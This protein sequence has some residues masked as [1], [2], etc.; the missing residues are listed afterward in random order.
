M[1]F[2]LV[3]SCREALSGVVSTRLIREQE[4][5]DAKAK[6]YEEVSLSFNRREK[7]V[8]P[9]VMCRRRRGWLCREDRAQR[10]CAEE[11]VTWPKV[12]RKQDQP[13]ERIWDDGGGPG[14]KRNVELIIQAEAARTRGTPLT[15]QAFQ[16][17]RIR[18]TNELKQKRDKEEDERIRALPPK[19]REDV[20]KRRE[21]LSG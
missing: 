3:A 12:K 14:T 2:T 20:R 6:A 15:P 7:G 9:G 18:F 4:A 21:R 10:V 19:E 13:S 8:Q 1:S 17:W 11:R 16:D 5:E